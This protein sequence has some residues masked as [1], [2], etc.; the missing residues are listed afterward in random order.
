MDWEPGAAYRIRYVSE[1]GRR[2]TRTI[3]VREVRRRNGM[4][5]LRA[6]CSL[7]GEERTFRSDR[8]LSAEALSV[9]ASQSSTSWIECAQWME[10]NPLS[11]YA[12]WTS[13][14]AEP[15]AAQALEHTAAPAVLGAIPQAARRDSS[16]ASAP[17]RSETESAAHSLWTVFRVLLALVLFGGMA[18]K[19]PLRQESSAPFGYPGK[20]PAAVAPVL[21]PAPVRPAAEE[22][23]LAGRILRTV[24]SGAS[25][26]FEVPSLGLVT[27]NKLEAIAAIRIPNFRA[28]TGLADRALEARYLAADLNRS[29]K[30]AFEELQAFQEQTSREFRYESNEPA[31]RPDEFL[32]AGGGDCEDFALYTAGLLRFWGWEPYLGILATAKGSSIGHAV[33]LS[34]EEGSFTGSY[35]WFQVEAWTTP[36]GAA[37][38]PGRYVP[39]DYDHVGALSN[40]VS[41]GW[42]LQE[43]YV[44]ESAWG[45]RM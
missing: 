44:P 15:A 39:I 33:C 7:R 34:F 4:I 31:L 36:D 30:L 29:G 12:S 26:R 38:K 10:R 6:W 25:E 41:P 22:T 45:Q 37:L 11:E 28:A 21:K 43:I 1:S 5:Y 13:R 17:A 20:A 18:S 40:A 8:V 35:T 32:A 16:P 27:F 24:R 9:P 2:S 3:E 42:K 19:L 23:V 14:A